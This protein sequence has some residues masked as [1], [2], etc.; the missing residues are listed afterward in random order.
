MTINDVQIAH[1]EKTDCDDAYD[2][3]VL[4]HADNTKAND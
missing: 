3:V 1:D 2:D 4:D